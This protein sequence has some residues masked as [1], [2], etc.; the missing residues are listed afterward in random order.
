[1]RISGAPKRFFHVGSRSR[2]LPRFGIT[3]PDEV[4]VI[5]RSYHLAA[6]S[7]N[8]L[9][10]AGVP[11]GVGC[12]WMGRPPYIAVPMVE[13]PT[14]PNGARSKSQFP[15]KSSMMAPMPAVAIYG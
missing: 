12:H 14:K 4:M 7:L 5:E 8:A 9:P 13:P 10:Q 1:M 15:W 6:A 3:V 2:K 11:A